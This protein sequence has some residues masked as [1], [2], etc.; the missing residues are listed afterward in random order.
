M[1]AVKL[2]AEVT[3]DRTL[4]LELPDEVT[5]GP[6]E[7]IILLEDSSGVALQQPEG[8]TLDEFLAESV[9]DH[10]FLRSKEQIDS[11]LAAERA[12]WE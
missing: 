6:A 1:R 7:V 9:V 12:A 3:R 4:R 8:G 10:R 2:K 5:E 11:Y